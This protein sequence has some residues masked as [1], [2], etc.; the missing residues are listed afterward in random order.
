MSSNGYINKSYL[1]ELPKRR[2][3]DVE[4]PKYGQARIQ[5]LTELERSMIELA[6][7]ADEAAKV[8]LK[9]RWVAAAVVDGEGRRIFAD[10][11]VPAIMEMDSA[12][13]NVLVDAIVDHANVTNDD[14]EQLAKN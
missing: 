7:L 13:I 11:D 1:L 14:R 12:V 2:Y 6:I 5:S 8:T 4:L 9:A 10:Q 3:R